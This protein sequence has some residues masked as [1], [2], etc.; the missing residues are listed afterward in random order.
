V[1]LLDTTV[2]IVLIVSVFIV[3]GG[4]IVGHLA[5]KHSEKTE[6]EEMNKANRK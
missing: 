1:R 4:P 5:S 2:I 6:K 3:I